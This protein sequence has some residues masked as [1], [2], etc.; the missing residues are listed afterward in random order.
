LTSSKITF[1]STITSGNTNLQKTKQIKRGGKM[2][3]A[4]AINPS[5]I[6]NGFHVL[7]L[8]RIPKKI[9]HWEV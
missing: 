2:A 1:I 6:I 9:Q 3:W 4:I 7:I 8:R 5:E